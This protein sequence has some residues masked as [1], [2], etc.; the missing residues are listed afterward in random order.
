MSGMTQLEQLEA[1]IISETIYI[2]CNNK[3]M[4]HSIS[5]VHHALALL[6]TTGQIDSIHSVKLLSRNSFSVN[7][8]PVRNCC[9]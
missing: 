4:P 8:T 2:G 3:L 1:V 7:L 5:D 6:P 9:A